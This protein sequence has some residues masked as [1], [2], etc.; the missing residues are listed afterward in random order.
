[1]ED[2]KLE[3]IALVLVRDAC[4]LKK[5]E[6]VLIITNPLSDIE[7]ISRYIYTAVEK[8]GG[9]PVIVTQKEKNFLDFA[10]KAAIAALKTEPQ[11]CFSISANKLGKD[12]DAIKFPFA[13]KEGE[14]YDH[15]FTYNLY[16]KKNMRA[17][18]APG[19]TLDMFERTVCIDYA[20]LQ[21][22]CRILS[23]KF[24]GADYVHV[25]APGGTDILV[26][27]VGRYGQADDGNF[28]AFGVGGNIP[29]GEV[30]I[31]PSLGHK[32]EKG[33][34]V[35]S[36]CQGRIVFDGSMSVNEGDFIINDPIIVDV[37]NGF[38]TE[39]SSKAGRPIDGSILDCEA[40]RLLKTITDAES[41]AINMEKEGIL[42]AGLGT[43]YAK[44]ARNI[45]EL[46][47]GLN[48]AALITGNMLE[49]E[50]ALKTCHFAI[51]SNYNNDANSLIHLDGVVRDPTIIIH[52]TDGTSFIVEKDGE[53]SLEL[54]G[55]K[56]LMAKGK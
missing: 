56:S 13:T 51:G 9:E 19:I 47:I 46:G 30:F 27:V 29:A 1:M 35:S 3:H 36:G 16:G 26:P 25:T 41:A 21:E 5:G 31:S 42:S 23:N 48:P 24:R 8:L 22:R 6:R 28:S 53:L 2:T 32:G 15:I 54:E 52:Y 10:N 33:G 50:K 49:D 37:V 11:L 55:A 12:E 38:V 4:R 43:E 18:W 44:N 17:L 39:I 7:Q 34:T 20:L 40:Y 45:G 14:T